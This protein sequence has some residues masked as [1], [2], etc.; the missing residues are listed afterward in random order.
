MADTQE[1]L[2]NITTTLALTD[3][4]RCVVTPG[5]VP[6]SK[7]IPLANF[8]AALLSLV[9][10]T[11]LMVPTLQVRTTADFDKTSDT[12]WN[13]V[14]GLSV[15]LISG[16]TYRFTVRLHCV[17][18][19]SGGIKVQL[20]GS[21]GVGAM[22]A[23]IIFIY[24]TVINQKRITSMADDYGMN[25]AAPQPYIEING[26]ISCNASGSFYVQFAQHASFATKSTV[27]TGSTLFVDEVT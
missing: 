3:Y 5:A 14:P 4:I 20:N 8:Q 13:Q 24:G 23:D 9:N 21:A 27:K 16:K 6:E 7:D 22:V 15:N 10:L 17:A 2:L 1:N 18:N 11:D 26:L 25:A 12:A 19:S